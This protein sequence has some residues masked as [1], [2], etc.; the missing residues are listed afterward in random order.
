MT[1]DCPFCEAGNEATRTVRVSVIHDGVV[2][3]MSMRGVVWQRLHNL[4]LTAQ[5]V[6][7]QKQKARHFRYSR[8]IYKGA[9]H[10]TR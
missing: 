9:H 7:S 3:A 8:M 4:A 2:E 1:N 10:G 5:M 6:E